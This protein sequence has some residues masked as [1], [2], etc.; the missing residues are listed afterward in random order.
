MPLVNSSKPTTTFANSTKSSGAELWSTITTTWAAETR[1]WLATL[2]NI[3]NEERTFLNASYEGTDDGLW[4]TYEQYPM[5]TQSF[6]AQTGVLHSAT[7][8]MNTEGN[9][10]GEM[11]AVL[12]AHSGVFGTSSVPTGPAL[13]VSDPLAL[14][15]I[16]S[17]TKTEVTFYF[18][19]AD[20]VC[21]TGGTNYCVGFRYLGGD[22]TDKIRSYIQFVG[23]SSNGNMSEYAVGPGWYSLAPRD[24]YFKLYTTTGLT[25]I[26]KPS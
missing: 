3:D 14:P 23:P 5:V 17:G 20:R 2:G 4:D 18:T 15:S 24:L 21:L 6:A 19:G 26:N 7:F 1:T 11:N 22:T 16:S 10:T 9:P 13:A 12:Y 25:N 8:S